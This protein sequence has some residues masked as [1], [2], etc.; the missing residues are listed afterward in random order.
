MI[1]PRLEAYTD[2]IQASTEE[3]WKAVEDVLKP[4]GIRKVSV[5]EKRIETKWIQD[6]VLRS[7]RVLP[8]GS[9][10]EI[11][12]LFDRRYRILVQLDERPSSTQIAVKGRFQIKSPENIPQLHWN[13][14][15]KPQLVDYEVEREM[16]YKILRRVE[17]SRRGS[18]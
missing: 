2:E 3:I 11:K 13:T 7:R 8:I 1:C 15:L 9:K 4:Y 6:R 16:F 18:I 12:Q 10:R 14:V 5:E 17:D